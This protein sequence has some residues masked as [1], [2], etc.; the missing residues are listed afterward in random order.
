MIAIYA[1]QSLDKKDSM[2][3]EGQIE[4]CKEEFKSREAKRKLKKTQTEIQN[5]IQKKIQYKEYADKGYSGKNT[6]RPSLNELFEDIK[7]DKIE[8]VVV[9]K[10]DRFSRNITDFFKMYEVMQEH[11]CDFIS[12]TDDFD[13]DTSAGRAMMTI[14]IAFAQMERENIQQRVKDNYYYR[15]SQDG[16]WAGGTPPYGFK[17]AKIDGKIPTLEV[18]WDKMKVVRYIFDMYANDVTVSLGTI[19]KRL[20][21]AGYVCTKSKNTTWDSSTVSKILQNTVYVQAD[22]ILYQYLKGRQ[23]KFLNDEAAWNGEHS[24]HIIGKKVGNGNVRKYTTLKEQS[25][26]VTN[27]EWIIDSRTYIRVMERLEQNEQLSNTTKTGVLQELGGKLKCECGYAIKS[28][29]KSTNGRPYLDCYANRSLHICNH[30]YNKFNF[31]EVQEEV[32]KQIQAKIGELK[33]IVNTK[34]EIKKQKRR[35]ISKLSKQRDTLV[36][37][38]SLSEEL[39]QATISEIEELQK[40][41]N[42]LQLDLKVNADMIDYLDIPDLKK[43]TNS[44]FF[45]FSRIDYSKLSTEEKKYIVGLMIE[46]IVLHEET[47]ELEFF[48][49]I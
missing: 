41:I 22:Q 9:Y 2:S 17:N 40:K 32:G 30:R 47:R 38:A 33:D 15:V 28:Y 21:E 46:K 13:T 14:L 1:R 26:Y 8:C 39:E 24:A 11:N 31:Y 20:R 12:V 48:W 16:R 43:Y 34:Q 6:E 18:D 49:K 23:I 25:V 7:E 4:L 35:E 3:I 37:M 19:A 27:F 45:S 10:L 44:D 42:K 29:S 36:K 5:E